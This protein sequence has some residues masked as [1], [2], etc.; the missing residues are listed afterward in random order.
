MQVLPKIGFYRTEPVSN[1]FCIFSSKPVAF[2]DTLHHNTE[3]SEQNQFLTNWLRARSAS[4]SS[5]RRVLGREPKASALL[6]A[7]CCERSISTTS[8]LLLPLSVCHSVILSFIHS[9]IHSVCNTRIYDKICKLG[10]FKLYNM[11]VLP[12]IFVFKLYDK[13]RFFLSFFLLRIFLLCLHKVLKKTGYSEQ[14]QFLT[15]FVFFPR[16]EWV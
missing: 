9:F 14:N 3:Y 7:L 8:T 6:R 5:R 13:S 11:Q 15:N 1:K 2:Q 4:Y 12:K 10:F 16:L